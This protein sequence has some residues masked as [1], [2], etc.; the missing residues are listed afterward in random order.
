MFFYYVGINECLVKEGNCSHGCKDLPIGHICT[1]RKGYKL[2]LDNITCVDINECKEF[3]SCTQSCINYEG[4][5][6]CMCDEGFTLDVGDKM[7]CR[8]S[9]KISYIFA[10]RTTMHM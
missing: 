6:A 10:S 2:S 9:G 5:Y 4:G 3:G 8:A 7:T 1:C